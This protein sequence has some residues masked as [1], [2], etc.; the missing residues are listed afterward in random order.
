[1]ATAAEEL[2]QI[3]ALVSNI[4]EAPARPT[5]GVATDEDLADVADALETV[6][7]D[8]VDDA[9]P[10][11]IAAVA[12][13]LDEEEDAIEKFVRASRDKRGD[14]H[15]AQSKADQI[16]RQAEEKAAE[17][18]RKAEESLQER[19]RTLLSS[20]LTDPYS[21]AQEFRVSP[22]EVIR[23]TAE[24][25][26]P[27]AKLL[28]DLRGE[29]ARRD[30]DIAE[31]KSFAQRV[32]AEK[33]TETKEKQR[34]NWERAQEKFLSDADAEN[35]PAL[36]HYWGRKRFLGEALEE[37][38]EIHAAAAVLGGRPEFTDRQIIVRLEKRAREELKAKAKELMALVQSLE[39]GSPPPKKDEK[40]APK[41]KPAKT[42]APSASA[43][44]TKAVAAPKRKF[45]NDA[46]EHAYLV[47]VAQEIVAKQAARKPKVA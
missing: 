9:S 38:Q 28:R 39:T 30:K 33:E 14:V 5:S 3:Q 23:A 8:T 27:N 18:L 6:E 16:L 22:D 1:M 17:V 37:T 47:K 26:D 45:K 21:A 24:A 36:N 19:A 41:A 7:P 13:V 12:A 43:A 32:V 46:E 2:A 34:A 10:T 31:L 11:A 15:T 40:E 25:S 42:I 4:E 35:F 20:M 29:L 44:S